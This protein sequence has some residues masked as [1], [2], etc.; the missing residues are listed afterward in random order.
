MDLRQVKESQF[1]GPNMMERTDSIGPVSHPSPLP[2]MNVLFNRVQSFKRDA[3]GPLREERG[4]LPSQ[5]H[6]TKSSRQAMEWQLLPRT[7]LI[8]PST[9][10]TICCHSVPGADLSTETSFQLPNRQPSY[11]GWG[12][13]R[14]RFPY[15]L[16][17]A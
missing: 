9:H 1:S 11:S 7:A 10:P 3:Q 17:S 6:Q 2:G 12:D 16:S 14:T 4:H 8:S 13:A 5:T 15:S